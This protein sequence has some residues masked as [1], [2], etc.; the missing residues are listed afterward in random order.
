LNWKNFDLGIDFTG[1]SGYTFQQNWESRNPFHDG[2]NNPQFYLGNQWHLSDPTD[3]TSALIPGKYPTIIVGNGG[4]S[5]YWNSTF[6]KYN[7]RYIKLRNLELGYNLPKAW[8]SRVGMSKARLY[9]M[10][11]N[12]FSI[13]NLDG[14]DPEITSDSGV[15]YPTNRVISVGVNVTF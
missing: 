2:G 8:V 15:Q 1:A 13:D 14:I 9:T 12:L 11:Q 7:G 4:H 3:A 10:A 5:N 6:W